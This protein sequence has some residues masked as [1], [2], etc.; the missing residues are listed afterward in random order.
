[1]THRRLKPSA[2]W[3]GGALCLIA[4]AAWMVGL[5]GCGPEPSTTEATP[6]K[7]LQLE[8]VPT[9]RVRLT[10]RPVKSAEIMTTGPYRVL[11]GDRQV[12][13]AN[14]RLPKTNLTRTDGS[15]KLGMLTASSDRLEILPAEGLVGVGSTRYRGSLVFL[16]DGPE[17][18]YIQNH[19]DMESYLASVVAKELYPGWHEECY[20][21]QAVAART[22]A[23]YEIATRGQSQPF[24]V[25]DSQR[26]QVYGGHGA[27]TAQS[28][29]AVRSTHAWVL[30][31]GPPGQEKIFLTQ[32][33]ACNGG[34]VNGAH[35]LRN[36]KEPIQPLAGGQRD[37]DGKSCPYWTWPT[38]TIPKKDLYRALAESYSRVRE[39][40]DLHTVGVAEETDYGRPVWITLTN[41]AG[42]STRLRAENLRLAMLRSD[43]PEAK[44][45]R[46]MN[47]EVLDVG[48]A[49][50]FRNGRGFGHGVGLSQWGAQEKARKGLSAEA[51]LQFYYPGS[52]IF[53]AY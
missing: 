20:R 48:E 41:T 14:A 1:M 32:F 36:V 34:V 16:A 51:I 28:W 53:R 37:P 9:V 49:V 21:A 52:G 18:F 50:E 42:K 2:A 29:N 8:G 47:C 5:G 43:L 46:S 40:G 4:A 10:A 12:A 15:W 26:S 35:V 30:A 17:S 11:A 25:W 24:D 13:N 38:V 23:L 7:P 31:F 33:S 39:L 22:Y 45:L 19:V 3:P 27:E 44:G 6:Q